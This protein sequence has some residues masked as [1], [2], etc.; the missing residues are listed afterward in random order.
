MPPVPWQTVLLV[1]ASV[2]IIQLHGANG[3]D[4]LK[5]ALQSTRAE[6]RQRRLVRV[7]SPMQGLVVEEV[8]ARW[9]CGAGSPPCESCFV[10]AACA[11]LTGFRRFLEFRIDAQLLSCRAGQSIE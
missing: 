5:S 11:V 8:P 10:R 7:M 1:A 9:A 4:T 6:R 2:P 3:K